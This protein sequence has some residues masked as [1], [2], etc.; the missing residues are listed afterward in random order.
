MGLN[1]YFKSTRLHELKKDLSK[2]KEF[3]FDDF[4]IQYE[5]LHICKLSCGWKPLFNSCEQFKSF[6]QIAEYYRNTNNIGIFDSYDNEYTWEGFFNLVN[7]K[8]V[9]ENRSHIE[10]FFEND[11]CNMQYNYYKDVDLYEFSYVDF[12]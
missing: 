2:Y 3:D 9:D 7:A 8:Q 5:G 1:F 4:F 11:V 6:R 12:R 10:I